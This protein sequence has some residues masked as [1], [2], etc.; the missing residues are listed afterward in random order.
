VDRRVERLRKDKLEGGG[1]EMNFL[2]RQVGG[3]WERDERLREDELKGSRRERT[4]DSRATE[5]SRVRIAAFDGLDET[6]E[7]LAGG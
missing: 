2:R 4:N 7:D 5:V 1:R 6:T 3:G